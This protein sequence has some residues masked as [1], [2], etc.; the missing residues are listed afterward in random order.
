M[1]G[2]VF[3]VLEHYSKA[4]LVIYENAIVADNEDQLMRFDEVNQTDV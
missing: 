3:E 4:G 1:P 2:G